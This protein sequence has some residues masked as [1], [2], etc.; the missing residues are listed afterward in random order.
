MERKRSE[1]LKLFVV[2]DVGRRSTLLSSTRSE[3]WWQ[4]SWPESAAP[5]PVG[6]LWSAMLCRTLETAPVCS[7]PR[8]PHP[9]TDSSDRDCS[10][11]SVREWRS[12]SSL[13][14]T[15]RRHCGDRRCCVSRC[16][17]RC[18]SKAA[19]W[20]GSGVGSAECP[21]AQPNESDRSRGSG[22][23]VSKPCASCFPR[24]DS[25]RTCW[26]RIRSASS[27]WS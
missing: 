2:S 15:A 4:S 11:G 26:R 12:V 27:C 3:R 16:Q 20:F 1:T 24:E 10:S 13:V 25:H 6:C 22:R 18:R 21:A 5:S 8:S 9:Q 23:A 14:V 7:K 17:I 19:S